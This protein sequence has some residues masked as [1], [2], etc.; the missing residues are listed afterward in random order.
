MPPM[1]GVPAALCAVA[2]SMGRKDCWDA[3]LQLGAS[4]LLPRYGQMTHPA[5]TCLTFP[6]TFPPLPTQPA[7]V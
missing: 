4:G 5:T 3:T 2:D 7:Q 6:P 1:M